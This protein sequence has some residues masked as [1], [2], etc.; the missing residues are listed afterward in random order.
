MYRLQTPGKYVDVGCGMR[1]LSQHLHM[2]TFPTSVKRRG[3]IKVPGYYR[4][5]VTAEAI[6]RLTHGYDAKMIPADLSEQ[7]QLGLYVAFDDSGL[8]AGGEKTRR[9]VGA[10]DVPDHDQA[11]FATTV[12][13]DKGAVPFINWDNG[14]GPS[15]WWMRDV[16]KKYHPDIEFHGKQ[17]SHAWHVVGKDLVPGRV[18][19]DVWNGPLLR[20]HDFVFTGPLPETFNSHAQQ[21]YLGGNTLPARPQQL[22]ALRKLAERAFRRP[23]S[24]EE[25][26]PYMATADDARENLGYRA[27]EAFI[28]A[29]K[30]ILVSPDFLYLKET[31]NGEG[32]LTDR[33]LATRM[34]YFLWGSLGDEALAKSAESANLA[35]KA[36]RRQQAAR[37]LADERSAD[38]IVG[39]MDSWLRYDKLG[40]MPPD[41]EIFR[42]Y[43]RWD[44][45]NAMRRE[46]AMFI[47]HIL[48]ENRPIGEFLSA[49]YTFVNAGLARLYGLKGVAGTQF[50]KASLH[51]NRQ[52]GGLIGHAGVL[53]LSAN[54]VDTSPVV[55]GV[56]ILESILGTPP[57][58]PPPDVEPLDPDTRGAST[59][60]QRLDKHRE[61]ETCRD[62]HIKI[63]P[64]GFPLEA[65]NAIGG[66]RDNYYHRRHWRRNGQVTVKN[67]GPKMDTRAELDS[68]ESIDDL[69]GLRQ[70]LLA[71]DK[72]FAR[73][74]T[75]K[76]L[77]YATG[78]KMTYQDHAEIE[79]IATMKPVT[80]YGFR[81][82]VLNV[83]E[84][85]IFA[86]R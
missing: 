80:E 63:D 56:W 82:L 50:R 77:T 59:L 76:L 3:G 60:R 66:Y 15:A 13:L 33:E 28:L 23:V 85:D 79:R 52:R 51:G 18:V 72:Q 16:C 43:Y 47:A 19:S 61:V 58:P 49:D 6:R 25:M 34:S 42:E 2:A 40:S 35:D 83:V 71:R 26:K 44:L 12:W 48:R 4:I 7:M 10:W 78:R 45:E 46:T 31:G 29:A 54:G 81:D 86:K 68:G 1:P 53:T 41:K 5:S 73:S 20:I 74:L 36:V 24:A 69:A 17:G 8:E 38:L 30:A 70:A 22:E 64:F 62:C 55:R 65:Y 9:R 11:A 14:P 21:S 37:M 57:A 27:T 39:L 32:K 84:S 67:R 75:E